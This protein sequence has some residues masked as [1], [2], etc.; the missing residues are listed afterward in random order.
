[1]P[2]PSTF[3]APQLRRRLLAAWLLA[4][5]VAAAHADLGEAWQ[6]ITLVDFAGAAA[7]FAHLATS[8]DPATAREAR[9]GRAIALLNA[10]PITPA[11]LREAEQLLA[12]I[13]PSPQDELALAARFYLARLAH[14]H[15]RPADLATARQRYA[16]LAADAS[17]SF[18]GQYALVEAAL[19]DLYAQPLTPAIEPRVLAWYERG[20]TVTDP[21]LRRNFLR[22][23]GLA[24]TRGDGSP[25]TA[26]RLEQEIVAL[27]FS[28]QDMRRFALLRVYLL[29]ESVGDRAAQIQA[30]EAYL[31]AYPHHPQRQYF[32]DR[33]AELQAAPAP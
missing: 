11:S 10:P 19:L 29:A 15:Q 31:P 17:Q 2:R 21:A 14:R 3:R 22:N 26:L 20:R 24:L 30:L 25:A 12:S 23:L 33:L 5:T 32:A 28:R 9:Y 1:M 4:G 18:F 27:N 6:K 8:S 13:P 7:D 16:A